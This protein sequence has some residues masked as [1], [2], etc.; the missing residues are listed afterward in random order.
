MGFNTQR[1]GAFTEIVHVL[2]V[3][4]ALLMLLLVSLLTYLLLPRATIILDN[5]EDE[6][7]N[8]LFNLN[9]GSFFLGTVIASGSCFILILILELTLRSIK[10]WERRPGKAYYS[11]R[12][13]SKIVRGMLRYFKFPSKELVNKLDDPEVYSL[14][15]KEDLLNDNP[16]IVQVFNK[17]S[18]GCSKSGTGAHTRYIRK[19]IDY[20]RSGMSEDMLIVGGV[21]I[22]MEE[23]QGNDDESSNQCSLWSEDLSNVDLADSS[24]KDGDTKSMVIGWYTPIT[25]LTQNN[26]S[27]KNCHSISANILGV[28]TQQTFQS[29]FI[30]FLRIF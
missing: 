4:T 27:I 6:G 16:N 30:V 9:A 24:L 5:V 19:F 13:D 1:F 10:S 15:L 11:I 7:D 8:M 14:F 20:L 23:S 18:V 29:V 25:Y 28:H 12:N 17:N 26:D 3:F 21:D 22:P 2:S